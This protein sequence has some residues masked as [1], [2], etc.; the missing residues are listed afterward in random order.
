MIYGEID[1]PRRFTATD[2]FTDEHGN[3]NEELPESRTSFD[4]AEVNG[5]TI[6]TNLTCYASEEARD[7]VIEM[8]VEAGVSSTFARLDKYLASLG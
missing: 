8:G 7:K 6:L 1:E 2:L 5:E 4:F 3:P